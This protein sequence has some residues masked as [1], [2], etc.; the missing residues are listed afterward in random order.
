MSTIVQS[1]RAAVNRKAVLAGGIGTFV[2]F[3]D[4]AIYGYFATTIAAVFFSNENAAVGL[5]Q[6]FAVFALSFMMRPL[7]GMFWGHFG[8]RIGRRKT[9]LIS[10]V[11]MGGASLVAGLLPTYAQ[12][13]LV[14]PLALLVTR[15]V[16]SFCAAGEYSGA[17]VFID[18]QAPAGKRVRHISVVPMGAASGFLL[19]S[20]LSTLFYGVLSD[21]ALQAWGWRVPFIAGGSLTM[22]GILVRRRLE[23]TPEF[24][25]LRA[26]HEVSSAPLL[27]GVRNHLPALIRA[28]CVMSVNAGGYYLVLVYMPTYLH[29]EVGLSEFTASTL[30]TIALV[31]YLPVLYLIARAGDRFGTR[32]ILGLNCVLFL[33]LSYPAFVLL[34]NAGT[35]RSFLLLLMLVLIFAIND[36]TFAAYFTESFPSRVRITEFAIPFNFGVAIFG[37][38]APL[39]ADWLIKVTGL[40]QSPAFFVMLIAGLGLA[41]LVVKP[42]SPKVGPVAE[43]HP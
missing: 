1:Q 32:R 35:V 41:A 8:D 12:I 34:N 13:G 30:T 27:E 29:T 16:Q 42:G 31:I 26:S 5:A 7:G 14:A 24:E 33:A 36:S 2:E 37:G 21:H 40:P 17:A 15:M 19:A 39:I 9:L 43:S 4:Y 20:L 25:Q 10:I 23:E 11:G 18:E 3:F 28:I 6:T 38:T 22:I